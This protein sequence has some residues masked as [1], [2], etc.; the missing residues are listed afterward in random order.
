[1]EEIALRCLNLVPKVYQLDKTGHFAL[2]MNSKIGTKYLLKVPFNPTPT[3]ASII[4]SGWLVAFTF[5]PYSKGI[6]SFLHLLKNNKESPF[7]SFSLPI[8]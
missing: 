3:I 7:I 5:L 8:Q 4:K 1:M 6:L 2:L